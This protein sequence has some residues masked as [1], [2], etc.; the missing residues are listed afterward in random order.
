[1]SEVKQLL[2]EAKNDIS[3]EDYDD[4]IK[5]S[6]KI[7][8]I[9]PK[10]YFANVFLGKAYSCVEK[11]LDKS[12]SSYQNAIDIDPNNQ[13]AWKGLFIVFKIPNCIPEI[14]S[15]DKYF[16]ICGKYSEIL[17]QQ[18]L[19]LVDLIHDIRMVRKEKPKCKESFLRHMTPGTLMGERLGRHFIK[20]QEALTELVK[21]IETKEKDEIAQLVSRERLKLSV[22]DPLYQTKINRISWGILEESELDE[23]YSQLV[24]ITNNDDER[25]KIEEKWLEYR[26]T[27]LN[28][29]PTDIKIHFF[30]K[31]NVMVS[32][33]VLVNHNSLL[34]WKYYFEWQDYLHLDDIDVSLIMKFFKKFPNEPLA[35]ILYSW[36]SSNF[37]K[38]NVQEYLDSSKE[39]PNKEQTD[40]SKTVSK[41]EEEEEAELQDLMETEDITAAVAEADI[42]NALI[43]SISEAQ[44]SILAHRIISQY[45]ILTNEYDTALPYIKNGILLVSQ[46]IRDFGASLANSKLEFTLDLGTAYTYVDSPK[47]HNAA[48]ALFD[49]IL[50]G[51][52][53]N[54]RVKLGKGI[55]YME[56]ENWKD[57]NKLLTDVSENFKD[58]MKIQSELAWSEANLGNLDYALELFN[59]VL[60]HVKGTSFE[61]VE[62]RLLTLWRQAK[63]NIFKQNIFDNKEDISLV[64]I[65]FKILIGI[66][67]L[68][69][70]YS[71]AY[72]L[73]G[74]I[75]SIYYNDKVRALKC[76]SKAFELNA[77]DV[78]AAKY[79][80]ETYA[81]V[82]N[83]DVAASVSER[84]VKSEKAK[85]EL[86]RENWPYR[87]I[88][89]SHL[90]KQRDADSIEWF[91]S[92]LRIDDQDI[93]S[94]V[95][96]GQAY[97]GCGR[98]EASVKVFQKALDLEPEHIFASYFKA[99][100]LSELGEF[101]ESIE[102]LE[103][104]TLLEKNNEAFLVSFADVSIRYAYDLY[105]QGFL[106]KSV[107]T[108]ESVIL[109]IENLVKN[110]GCTS[111]NLWIILIKALQLYILVASQ[112]D[113][114][115]LE[116]CISIFS[117]VKYNMI[118]DLDEIDNVTLDH[119]M[120]DEEMDNKTIVCILLIL[121]SKFAISTNINANTSATVKAS[122]WH[123]IGTVE[124]IAY[125]SLKS[126]KYRECAII[127]FKNSI[128][129]QSNSAGTWIG[130]GIAIMDI[131][132]RVA[133]HCFIKATALQPKDTESWFNLAMLGLQNNDYEFSKSVLERTQSIAPHL[134]NT[135]FGLAL[136][137]ELQGN[138]EESSKFFA[139]AFVLSKGRSKDTQLMYAKNVLEKYIG[140][141]DTESDL[142]VIEE[143]SA[144]SYGLSQYFKKVSD[145]P[146][147]L[148]CYLLA[149]ERIHMYPLASEYADKLSDMLETRFSKTQNEAELINY[150]Y[151]KTQ[152]ARIQL[153]AGKYKEAIESVELSQGLLQD[154]TTETSIKHII[155]NHI[156]LGLANFFLDNFDATLNSFQ[157]LL[158]I[159]KDSQDI[160]ILISKI[161]YDVGTPDTKDIAIEELTEYLTNSNSNISVLLTLAS[162]LIL[163]DDK[164]SLKTILH[165]LTSLKLND[166]ISDRERNA[167]YLI[168][169]IRNKISPKTNNLQNWQ[170]T[171]MF[172]PNDFRAWNSIDKKIS[173][174]LASNGQNK[175]SANDL[176][177]SL[178]Q[179]KNLRNIQRSLFLTPWKTSS[180][181]ALNDCF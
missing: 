21:I 104:I 13:L 11:S 177:E 84:L 139:H 129:F 172:F 77:G 170:R 19:P 60:E 43:T 99:L 5:T 98:V 27:V 124:L 114:V 4:A 167:T 126:L 109:I 113:S 30:K 156:C 180:L 121:A 162:I 35:M 86:K 20:P 50:A 8:K 85:K 94:W 62:I 52:P 14:F 37:T 51:E 74:Q 166:L 90:E 16:D 174:R 160:V 116:N 39:T 67:K 73:L 91:Q 40:V 89:I 128:K 88:G 93:E 6:K 81:N 46:S 48:L 154:Q 169:K 133:Q 181:N 137:D 45:F 152:I 78:E 15:F 127:S 151:L 105:S 103:S 55:I 26:I 66:I 41:E 163:E 147:A 168:E 7:L 1:M 69:D 44:N 75:Y 76:Y 141:T 65:A 143:L 64:T 68:S 100:A 132:F 28:S 97:F 110:I 80:A 136:V 56:R 161:L 83:W 106:I 82:S 118:P 108:S 59:K 10:N 34:P 29:M 146:F 150:A 101:M 72:S 87:T 95:G 155:S 25:T 9:D 119:L 130:L 38:Y 112:I 107:K 135:W 140:N 138:L 49:K 120:L 17:L 102:L 142:G 153:G 18:Q 176:S 63:T 125:S 32:D 23:F 92:A 159:S 2:K 122:L 22:S 165:E 178:L 144:A 31:V 117:S 57:A 131:N 173:E 24:N 79:I 157:E 53:D 58:D 164:E 3:R 70:T 123:N 115:P 42:M 179:V 33:M 54:I 175:V 145:D 61:E 47:Y 134:S 71:S 12:I 148:E 96:L 111:Q 36:A 171:A 158:K 149:L